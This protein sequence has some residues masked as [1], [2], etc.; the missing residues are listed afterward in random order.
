MAKILIIDDCSLEIKILCELLNKEYE[1]T[2]ATSGEAGIELA[3][4][5]KPDLILL[6]I[7][8]PGMDG[9]AA[10]RILKGKPGLADIPVLFITSAAE[11]WDII[12][13]FEAGGQDYITKPFSVQELCARIRVHLDLKESKETVMK[14]ARVLEEKNHELNDLLIKLEAAAMTD[15]LTGLANRRY[16]IEHIKAEAAR[17]KR[18]PGE[19]T[20]I[21]ADIDNFKKINDVYGHDCGDMVL[22]D[23]TSLIRSVTRQEDVLARWGGEEFLLLLTGS[24]LNGGLIAAEKIRKTVEQ[25]EFCYQNQK[26]HLTITL[27]VTTLDLGMGLDWSIHNADEALYRG[28]QTTKNCV[29]AWSPA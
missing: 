24:G 23:V 25:A 13:G 6:D 16:M 27:G 28:K 11:T 17:L 21:L 29:I 19:A 26:F 12:R 9:L 5:I 1:V 14:Y 3:G 2:A 18:N 4:K 22:K 7:I 10:C 8:M 15:Y 20:L